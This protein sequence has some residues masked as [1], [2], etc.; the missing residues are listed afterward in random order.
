VDVPFRDVRVPGEILVIPSLCGTLWVHS[1][2]V[3]TLS[4]FP[5]S[6]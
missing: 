1:L 6:G 4:E 5:W 3:S 2:L